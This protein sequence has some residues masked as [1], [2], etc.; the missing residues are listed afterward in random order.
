MGSKPGPWTR[1]VL[2]RV[3]EWQLKHPDGIKDEC[4]AWL[5]AE[6]QAGRIRV[7]ENTRSATKRGKVNEGTSTAKKVKMMV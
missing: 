1:Q 7:E 4:E 3:I 2:V 5:K 6:K